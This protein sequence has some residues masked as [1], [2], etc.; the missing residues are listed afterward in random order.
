MAHVNQ[1]CIV[2]QLDMEQSGIF[3]CFR[4]HRL[5][6]TSKKENAKLYS[7]KGKIELQRMH[8]E[9]SD[10]IAVNAVPKDIIMD[11]SELCGKHNVCTASL[12]KFDVAYSTFV[13]AD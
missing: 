4:L 12:N 10:R 9:Q 5:P 6:C 11:L 1:L 13:S 8:S 7:I 3:L 2:V